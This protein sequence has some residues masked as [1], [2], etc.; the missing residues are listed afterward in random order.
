MSGTAVITEEMLTA[1]RSDVAGLLSEY[2]MA[3][4][5]GVEEMAAELAALFCPEKEMLLRAA[6]LLH[7]VT[8][9]LSDEEQLCIMADHGVIL[10]KDE[11]ASPQIWHAVTAAL[12]IGERYAP[13]ASTELISA[14]RWHATGRCGMTLTEALIYLADYIER[15]RTYG[16]CIAVREAFFGA[17]PQ[18]MKQTA[19][20]QLLRNVLLQSYEKTIQK[21][22]RRGQGICVDTLNAAEDLK[23]RTEI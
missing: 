8:K 15:G 1:L 19:R 18:N 14:V 5:L 20:R 23:K 9:E 17:E 6:A 3:H 22:Q 16:D 7:D 13:F 12:I 4:T 11:Q 2:R 10:R 21:L